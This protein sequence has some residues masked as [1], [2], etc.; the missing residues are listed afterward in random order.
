MR[1]LQSFAVS[2]VASD[3]H[4]LMVLKDAVGYSLLRGYSLPTS[5]NSWTSVR[6]KPSFG[7]DLTCNDWPQSK[8]KTHCNKIK[9]R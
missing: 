6:R 1:D 7:L 5:T 8:S 4:G 9:I 3:W 2:E